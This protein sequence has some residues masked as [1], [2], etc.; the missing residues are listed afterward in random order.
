MRVD[1]D[2]E[3]VGAEHAREEDRRD[4]RRARAVA[5]STSG[6]TAGSAASS[7][8]AGTRGLVCISSPWFTAPSTSCVARREQLAQVLRVAPRREAGVVAQRVLGDRPLRADGAVGLDDAERR[9]PMLASSSSSRPADREGAE[10]HASTM[11]PAG[12]PRQYS[13][14]GEVV[15]GRGLAPP[16]SSSREKTPRELDSGSNDPR[17]RRSAIQARGVFSDV[18]S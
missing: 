2:A 1:A 3:R 11:R 12:P 17:I 14:C 5:V 13:I 10:G 8:A 16:H 18:E 15:K 9:E 7:R 4:R 6:P